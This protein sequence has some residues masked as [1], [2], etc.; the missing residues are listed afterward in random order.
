MNR[1]LTCAAFTMFLSACTTM[2]PDECRV[3]NWQQIGYRDGQNGN[4]PSIIQRYSQDCAEAG[5]VADSDLWRKGFQ[6]GTVLYCSPDNGYRV[7]KQGREYYG[8]CESEQFL[9]NYQLG[10]QE[11]LVQQRIAEIDR[12]IADIDRQMNSLKDSDKDKQKRNVLQSKRRDLVRERSS[13]LS[14][15]YNINFSF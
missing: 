15:S 10:R 13:L 5:V 11:Y 8:V 14:P 12:Q 2:S 9:N 6:Q 7:G 4:D 3:A 1:I